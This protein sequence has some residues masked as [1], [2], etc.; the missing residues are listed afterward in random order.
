MRSIMSET[1]KTFSAQERRL[2]VTIFV[3][4]IA[5]SAAFLLFTSPVD[6]DDGYDGEIT[7]YGYNVTMGLQNPSQVE[8]VEWNFGDGSPTETVTISASNAN[9]EVTHRYASEGDYVVTATMRNSYDGG[10]ETVLTYL[11][12]IMGFPTITFDSQGGSSVQSIEG[13]RSSFVASQPSAPTKAGFTFTGWFLDADCTQ[14]YDWSTTVVRDITLYAGWSE[15]VIEYTVTFDMNGA[16]GSI[17]SQTV[18][19]GNT[20][21][22][23]A[24]PSRTGFVFMGWQYNGALWN[25]TSPVTSNMTLV[26]MWEPVG[27]ETTYYVVTFDANG[28]TAGYTQQNVLE[29]N[30]VVLPTATR[31]GYTFDGWYAG[32]TFIGNAGDS[33]PVSSNITLTAHWTENAND[34]GDNTM[35][36]ILAIV[37]GILAIVCLIVAYYVSLYTV[38]G[39]VVFAIAALVCGLIYGGLI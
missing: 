17:D 20:I 14:P 2:A 32:E 30:S 4:V 5:A 27:S 24:N 13:T 39:T 36:L 26:A 38:I 12:H 22:E 1:R 9:G 35:W 31:D 25:F 3:A 28:G 16:S 37:C 29:G 10:S 18:V 19:S 15:E 11:Y 34:D 6:A 7:L 33:Y 21:S 23:P 8:T